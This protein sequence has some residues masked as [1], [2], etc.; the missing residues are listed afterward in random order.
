LGDDSD[1]ES[2]GWSFRE[3]PRHIGPRR[4]I[5]SRRHIEPPRHIGPPRFI[6]RP[7]Y[8][9]ARR[10][11]EARRLPPVSNITEEVR[12]DSN[13][14]SVSKGNRREPTKTREESDSESV[15]GSN[16]ESDFERVGIRYHDNYGRPRQ[17]RGIAASLDKPR[18]DFT[19]TL[20]EDPYHV[21]KTSASQSTGSYLEFSD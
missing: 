17:G 16:S 10:H 19:L 1:S 7:R 14:V 21:R 11:I 12:R 20:P 8:I 18:E 13:T 5:G 4:N 3:R 6:E 15:S 2:P 9:E